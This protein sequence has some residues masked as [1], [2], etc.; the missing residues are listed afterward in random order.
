[1]AYTTRATR[2][3]VSA[4]GTRGGAALVGAGLQGDVHGGTA[5]VVAGRPQRGDFCV[6]L[7]G[8]LVPTLP[9]DALAAGDHAP[10][11]RIRVGRFHAAGS[12]GQRPLHRRAV[13]VREH[14]CHED[15]REG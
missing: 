10:N 8:A 2:A 4:I 1:M 9:D 12:Q 15:S 6:C 5:G 7:P 11:P 13:E 3:A 14:G